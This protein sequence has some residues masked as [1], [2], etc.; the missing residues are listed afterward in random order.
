MFDVVGKRLSLLLRLNVVIMIADRDGQDLLGLVLLDDE[1]VEMLLHLTRVEIEFER[2]LLDWWRRNII[3]VRL[4]HL[5]DEAAPRLE[6]TPQEFLEAGV[7]RI[8]IG[9]G[10]H[11]LI[12]DRFADAQEEPSPDKIAYF[13]YIFR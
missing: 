3:R 10:R 4:L 8:G 12:S 6:I 5:G 9:G 2:A 13:P 11:A 1:A 7:E